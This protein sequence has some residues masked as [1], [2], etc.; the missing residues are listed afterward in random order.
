M[1]K[2]YPPIGMQSAFKT[3]ASWADGPAP[4][5]GYR[6]RITG[7]YHLPCPTEGIGP[8]GIMRL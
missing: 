5:H 6:P 2:T 3:F 7:E 1:Q 8:S 4:I